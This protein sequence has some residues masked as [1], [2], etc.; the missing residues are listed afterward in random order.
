MQTRKRALVPL[1]VATWLIYAGVCVGCASSPAQ[2]TED[3]A[4][5]GGASV[6][7][8]EGAGFE[9][10]VFARNRGIDDSTLHIYFS[11]DGTPFI[12][13]TQLAADPTPRDPLEVRL[14]LE[15]PEPSV[16]IGRPCYQGLATA[17]GCDPSLW[18]VARYSE[19]V[20][21]SMTAA[22]LGVLDASRATQITLIG[23]SGGGVLAVL[24]AQRVA[25]IS[26]VVTIAANLDIDAWAQLHGYSVL[27]QSLNPAAVTQWRGSLQQIHLVGAADRNV[28]PSIV[29]AFARTQSRADVRIFP[30]FDHRCCW[31]EV[32][33]E[34]LRTF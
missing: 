30:E 32:W 33:P 11:G 29:E 28:P 9:H 1:R 16:F 15:D 25:R 26:T 18:S 21:A 4:R 2:H 23:Y 7:R 22:V 24:V 3:L 10:V 19:A 17:A 12:R 20:V 34:L 31:V 13:P 14:M 5:I 6:A 8:V 27:S